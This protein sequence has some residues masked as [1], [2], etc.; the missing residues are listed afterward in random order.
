V[1]T[2]FKVMRENFRAE[3]FAPP[4]GWRREQPPVP[5]ASAPAAGG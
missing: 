5:S 2:L 4:G 3:E 1:D